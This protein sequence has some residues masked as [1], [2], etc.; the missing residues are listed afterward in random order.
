M[1]G[2]GLIG[3]EV[4]P[5]EQNREVL[6]NDAELLRG[7]KHIYSRGN[8][9]LNLQ[10]IASSQTLDYR[11]GVCLLTGGSFTVTLPS[12]R[13]WGTEKSPVITLIHA[14][15]SN[16]TVACT[17]PDIF[18]TTGTNTFTLYVGEKVTLF[19]DGS[20][21]YFVSRPYLNEGQYRFP[22]AQNASSDANTL[23]DYEEGTWTPTIA[24]GSG[25]FTSVSATGFYTKI[26]NR[27]NYEVNIVITTN[28]TAASY[29]QF[30]LPFTAAATRTFPIYGR[31]RSGLNFALAGF[32]LTTTTGIVTK[33]DGTYPGSSGGILTV[34]GSFAV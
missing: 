10:S 5:L 21:T 31:E 13:Y 30:T 6:T 34:G 15:S 19:T 18:D 28:G 27:V 32:N 1:P 17:T 2:K 23:D 14:G 25:T 12:S 16:I 33:Y 9:A 3:S 11:T 22:A 4:Q 24:A 20:A 8:L 7:L 26:G 29:V